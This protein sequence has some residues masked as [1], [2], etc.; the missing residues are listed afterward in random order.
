MAVSPDG[1]RIAG[2]ATDGGVVVWSQWG[3][4]L[5]KFDGAAGEGWHPSHCLAFS[6]D[7]RFLVQAASIG[8]AAFVVLDLTGEK[9]VVVPH[10]RTSLIAFHPSWNDVLV[11]AAR[12]T[13]TFWRLGEAADA[14][15]WSL[16]PM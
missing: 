13:I 11:T 4:R 16:I 6:P 3:E 14:P 15:V 5:L 8:G 2:S 9:H 1:S 10:D 7:G 12:D